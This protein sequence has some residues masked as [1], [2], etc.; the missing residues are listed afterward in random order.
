MYRNFRKFLVEKELSMGLTSA[1]PDALGLTD[2]E[3]DD[4]KEKMGAD[5]IANVKVGDK[6]FTNATFDI[7]D[8][9]RDPS[10]GL[11][12]Q[13][14]LKITPQKGTAIYKDTKDGDKQKVASIE[15]YKGDENAKPRI[16]YV[17][18][19]PKAVKA[20]QD[21]GQSPEQAI[22]ATIDDMLGQ[23]FPS[24]DG[25]ASTGMLPGGGLL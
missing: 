18:L 7:L 22:K 3:F 21:Q 5:Y 13:A 9:T 19:D 10:T 23:G 14:K 25:G 24:G 12:T 6:W 16:V 11:V 17:T 8:I 4:A 20:K 1:T 15:K 2:K